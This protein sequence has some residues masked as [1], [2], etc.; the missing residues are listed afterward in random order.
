MFRKHLGETGSFKYCEILIPKLLVNEVLRSLHGE[1][2]KHP[3]IAKTTIAYKGKKPSKMAQL[4]IE[5]VMSCEQG[6]KK[7]RLDRN[8]THPPLQNTNEH[9]N[10]PED[11]MQFDLVPELPPSGG[12]ENKV[13]AK[14]M[15]SRQPFVYPTANQDSKAFAKVLLN[16]ITR[17]AYLPTTLISDKGT[18]FMSHVSKEVAGVL[19]ITLKPATTKHTQTIGLLERS[20]ASIKQ[21][22]KI[23]TGE[24]RPL[25]HKYVRIAV[26]QYNTSHHK[27]VGCEPSRRFPGRIPYNVL[28][29]NLGI[30]PQ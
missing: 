17:H 22:L 9:N 12:Y 4:I 15:I 24:Q 29:L 23:E 18:A 11:A 16:I 20:H 28:D 19:G 13:I 14:Y 1:F 3:G 5:W 8:L 25:W 2:G 6:I 10:P 27:S 21:T 26:L 7:L 30:G